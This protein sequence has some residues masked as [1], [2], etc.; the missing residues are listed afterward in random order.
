MAAKLSFQSNIEFT[1]FI[2]PYTLP[3]LR[4]AALIYDQNRSLESKKCVGANLHET[5]LAAAFKIQ[6]NSGKE[7]C[8]REISV[9]MHEEL[10]RDSAE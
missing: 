9:T 2:L 7:R 4:F 10:N 1:G 6:S 8:Y 5:M 3:R